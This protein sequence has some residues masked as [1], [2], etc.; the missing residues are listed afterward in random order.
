MQVVPFVTLDISSNIQL[1][2]IVF[3]RDSFQLMASLDN[4]AGRK[5]IVILEFINAH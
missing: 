4:E 5:G 1:V 3:Y 2:I